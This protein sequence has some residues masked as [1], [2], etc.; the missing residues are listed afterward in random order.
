[1]EE[2]KTRSGLRKITEED[3]PTIMSYADQGKSNREIAELLGT[4]RETIRRTIKNKRLHKEF[5]V[6]VEKVN[7]KFS[8][9]CDIP[10][11][12][13]LAPDDREFLILQQNVRYTTV[14]AYKEAYF[15]DPP[16]VLSDE[17]EAKI[18]F[19]AQKKLIELGKTQSLKKWVEAFISPLDIIKSLKIGMS[20][21]NGNERDR[22]TKTVMKIAGINADGRCNTIM[23]NSIGAAEGKPDGE[24]PAGLN[25]PETV[26][27]EVFI[28]NCKVARKKDLARLELMDMDCAGET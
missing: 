26:S 21:G 1:M 24:D 20:S 25:L 15:K 18:T 16:G 2:V 22:V 3:F 10:G 23:P 14:M 7:D 9:E 12:E 8:P 6:V 11:A 27:M 28:A 19:L 17:E 13:N 4:N 5:K